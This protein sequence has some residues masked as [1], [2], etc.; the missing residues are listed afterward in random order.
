[1]L[2][3]VIA[4]SNSVQCFF[5]SASLDAHPLKY[6][7]VILFARTYIFPH[8]GLVFHH[9]NSLYI[10]KMADAIVQTDFFAATKINISVCAI[11]KSNLVSLARTPWSHEKER[12]QRKYLRWTVHDPAALISRAPPERVSAETLTSDPSGRR[13]GEYPISPRAQDSLMSPAWIFDESCVGRP[14]TFISNTPDWA[15]LAPASPWVIKNKHV[16]D[17]TAPS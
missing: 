10:I 17:E 5:W 14:I 9:S 3:L 8:Q 1:M 16:M 6:E 4:L 11:K 15:A 7:G 2:W 12:R 13:M